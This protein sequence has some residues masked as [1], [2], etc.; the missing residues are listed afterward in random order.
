MI[1]VK[2]DKAKVVIMDKYLTAISKPLRETYKEKTVIPELLKSISEWISFGK[3]HATP[4]LFKKQE[5]KAFNISEIQ[6]IFQNLSEPFRTYLDIFIPLETFRTFLDLL[7][8][9]Y[10][11]WI[12]LRTFVKIRQIKSVLSLV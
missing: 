3:I 4:F 5:S 2:E 6:M 1:D 10:L 11:A 8:N 9:F 7:P 12:S